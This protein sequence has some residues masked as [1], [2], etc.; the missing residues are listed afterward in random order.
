L[1]YFFNSFLAFSEHVFWHCGKDR[2]L[3]KKLIVRKMKDNRVGSFD[4]RNIY[5]FFEKLGFHK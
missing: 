1:S 3:F 2:L 4:S 5:I